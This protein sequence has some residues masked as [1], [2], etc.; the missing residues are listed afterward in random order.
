[1]KK[2]FYR[3]DNNLSIDANYRILLSERCVGK[4]YALKEYVLKN[5]Y[6]SNFEQR[7]VYLRRY[8]KDIKTS[9]CDKYFGDMPIDKITNGDFDGVIFYRGDFYFSKMNEKTFRQERGPLIGYGI[10]LNNAEHYKSLVYAGVEDMIY[11]EFIT[12][13]LYLPNEPTSLQELVSTVARERD[14]NVWLVGNKIDSVCPYFNEWSLENTLKQKVGTID[15]YRYT[16][17]KPDGT[18]GETVV[19]VEQCEIAGSNSSMFFGNA[20]KSIVGGEWAS[21][22]MPHLPGVLEDYTKLYELEL[23]DCGFSFMLN[24]LVD[25]SNGG[26]FLYVYPKTRTYRKIKRVITNNFST[27]PLTSSRFNDKIRAEVMMRNC[28]TLGKTCYSDNLTGTNFEKVLL[29]R[30]GVL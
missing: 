4:S 9:K 27:D 21:K 7:F 25:E 13:Q 15:I 24:L 26:V 2:K 18:V 17:H 5:A 19:T 8:E 30:K 12:D 1:M 3:L 20:S 23:Q 16:H 10:A 6:D 11:E 28:I 22:E 14:I 29:S